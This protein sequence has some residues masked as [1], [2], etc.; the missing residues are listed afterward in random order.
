MCDPHGPPMK[1]NTPKREREREK[2]G[3]GGGGGG[4][5]RGSPQSNEWW[6]YIKTHPCQKCL[7]QLRE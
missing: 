1:V 6:G 2:G 3:A 5:G 4:R 7:W